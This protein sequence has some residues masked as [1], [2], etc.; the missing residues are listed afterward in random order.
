MHHAPPIMRWESPGATAS[1]HGARRRLDIF[2]SPSPCSV[3]TTVGKVLRAQAGYVLRQ[4]EIAD[5][6]CSERA[7]T[8]M[9]VMEGT[10]G[11][12][13]RPACWQSEPLAIGRCC[14]LR[15]A[16]QPPCR[17]QRTPFRCMSVR[18]LARRC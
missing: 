8:G 11:V 12:M 6:Q 3:M 4:K 17:R 13:S 7:D 2:I 16:L 10:L 15:Y 14:R 9:N 1:G 5:T 18:W